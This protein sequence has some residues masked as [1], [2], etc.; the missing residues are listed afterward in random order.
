MFMAV[1][2][3][4]TRTD[5]AGEIEARAGLD[6]KTLKGAIDVIVEAGLS[7]EHAEELE[8]H[9]HN[10][11]QAIRERAFD[12]TPFPNQP[13]SAAPALRSFLVE[14]EDTMSEYGIG[15]VGKEVF[16]KSLQCLEESGGKRDRP[17][18]FLEKQLVN[19]ADA[20]K[21]EVECV[22]E[23]FFHHMFEAIAEGNDAVPEH[24]AE[25]RAE[26]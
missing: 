15:E 1:T 25:R 3:G 21:K 5:I 17:V 6:V 22:K 7:R 18:R 2:G 14:N 11:D 8:K 26:R 12:L 19:S 9:W 23:I 4:S 24:S 16:R 10:W 20:D 13:A